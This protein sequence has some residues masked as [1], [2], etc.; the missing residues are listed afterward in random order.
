MG[1]TQRCRVLFEQILVEAPREKSSVR[2]LSSHKPPKWDEQDV[3]E[4]T[5][6]ARIN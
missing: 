4:A 3:L 2:Y 1:I 5:E 6:K